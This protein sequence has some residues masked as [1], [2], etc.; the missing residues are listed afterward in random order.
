MPFQPSSLLK[1]V[2]LRH[3]RTG[4]GAPE[5][6]R[7]SPG[8]DYK[9][10][11]HEQ[12]SSTSAT[13]DAASD[14]IVVEDIGKSSE[15]RPMILAVISSEANIKNRARYQEIARKLNL[16]RG[17]SET[18]ARA[19]AKEGKVIV[20]I[21]GGLHATEVAGA[22]HT[23]ELAGGWSTRSRTKPGAFATTPSCC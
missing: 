6:L 12:L 14:R 3:T 9:L 18:E 8:A 22:Q 19:L 21:D 4:S 10:A 2:E 17:V 5:R 15:G 23:P 11:S 1:R 7:L 13:L 16:A 20:W